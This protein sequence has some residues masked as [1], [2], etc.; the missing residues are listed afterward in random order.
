[1]RLHAVIALLGTA[2]A[3]ESARA[4]L[5]LAQQTASYSGTLVRRDST[6]VVSAKVRLV[7]VE[8]VTVT[9]DSG[10][11]VFQN[12]LPGRYEVSILP[13]GS[14]PVS[15]EVVLAPG[16]EYHTRIVLA[17]EPQ[18]LQDITVSTGAERRDATSRR[19]E[20]FERRRRR[21]LGTFLTA[22]DL[23]RRN[24]R[25]LSDALV[26]INGTRVMERGRGKVLISSRGLAPTLTAGSVQ[27]GPC[28]LRLIIDGVSL[29]G[30]TSVDEIK[31]E[32]VAGI[33]I[34]AGAAQLPVELAHFQED[35]WCG[36][37]VVWT[38]GG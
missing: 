32:E 13:P 38:R 5:A 22:D 1:M 9:D 4:P 11:F 34:Y 10:R 28:I 16:E 37:V 31:P 12:V 2:L 23:A 29:P 21:G 6:P 24:P 20:A 7:R 17:E 25:V 14:P 15:M 3:G 30:G 19:L 35:T 8:R 26:N 36:A 33:E 18:R 27:A